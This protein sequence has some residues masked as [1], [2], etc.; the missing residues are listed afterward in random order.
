MDLLCILTL[1]ILLFS[2]QVINNIGSIA[3]LYNFHFQLLYLRY[4]G[5]LIHEKFKF[6][7]RKNGQL[8]NYTY[9]IVISAKFYLSKSKAV[10]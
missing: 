4:A 9:C 6:K 10:V 7:S 3:F 1:K 5:E 8:C 2:N